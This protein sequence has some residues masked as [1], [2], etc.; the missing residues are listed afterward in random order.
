MSHDVI[1]LTT[2]VLQAVNSTL[3]SEVLKCIK[4]TKSLPYFPLC[5]LMALVLLYCVQE[6]RE[7][8]VDA[9]TSEDPVGDE[10]EAVH[11]HDDLR[12]GDFVYITDSDGETCDSHVIVM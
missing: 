2:G 10:R 5:E 11:F 9:E 8:Q 1:D 4:T 3:S 12:A 6:R 7:T